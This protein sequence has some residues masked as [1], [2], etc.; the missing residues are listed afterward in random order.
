[1]PNAAPILLDMT[2][3]SVSGATARERVGIAAMRAVTRLFLR[4]G[5]RG[6]GYALRGIATVLPSERWVVAVFADDERFAFPYGDRYWSTLFDEDH[7]YSAAIDAFVDAARGLD[8]VFVDCGANFGYWSVRASAAR[9]GG[10]EAIAIEASGETVAA[11]E[12]NAALNDNRFPVHHRAIAATSGERLAL[13]GGAKHEQ[14]SL[15]QGEAG[16]AVLEVVETLAIDDLGQAERGKPLVLKLDVEGFEP[17]AMA[18][19]ARSL[20]ADTLVIY[21]DHGRDRAHATSRFMQDQG[22]RIFRTAGRSIFAEIRN[23]AE[24][25]GVKVHATEGYDFFATRSP[26]WIDFLEGRRVASA[27]AA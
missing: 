6:L 21:E 1:M 16:G 22:L 4:R 11:L 7:V 3:R 19:A 5:L 17:Q 13:Y 14:R 12:R 25:D 15:D 26:F 10:H 24:L 27:A 23:L 8:Y 18:G 9:A 20:A 2:T